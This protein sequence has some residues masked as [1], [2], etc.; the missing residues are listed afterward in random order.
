MKNILGRILYVLLGLLAGMHFG[1]DIGE[2]NGKVALCQ[3]QVDR[4]VHPDFQARCA[5]EEGLV[6]IKA[7]DP[8]TGQ[9][10]TIDFL[11][12]RTL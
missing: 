5:I 9:N 4:V 8:N 6:V 10:L 11:T 3:V 12:G 2:E 1:L 7:T